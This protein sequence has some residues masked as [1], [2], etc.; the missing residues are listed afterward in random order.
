MGECSWSRRRNGPARMLPSSVRALQ[1]AH[2]QYRRHTAR[3][4]NRAQARATIR[5]RGQIIELVCRWSGV[6]VLVQT[7]ETLLLRWACAS[8]PKTGTSWP[9]D[10]DLIGLCPFFFLDTATTT[11]WSR[12]LGAEA[13][14]LRAPLVLGK[15]S[16]WRIVIFPGAVERDTRPQGAQDGKT[17]KSSIPEQSIPIQPFPPGPSRLMPYMT[18]LQYN[19]PVPRVCLQIGPSCI[20]PLPF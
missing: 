12:S 19:S 13:S 18:R 1:A 11:R 4:A 6:A 15:R 3:Q 10:R 20:S 16:F 8:L 9:A 2:C 5:S 14:A 7:L 17:V